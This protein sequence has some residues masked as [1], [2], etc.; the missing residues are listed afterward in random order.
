MDAFLIKN[1]QNQSLDEP[2]TL[3][4]TQP[5]TDLTEEAKKVFESFPQPVTLSA[6]TSRYVNNA[7]NHKR[8]SSVSQC[9][10]QVA[11]KRAKITV[12][13]AANKKPGQVTLTLAKKNA[14]LKGLVSSLKKGIKTKNFYN[15]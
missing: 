10:P 9:Q 4:T 12:N 15:H 2:Q 13:A 8:T 14:F 11:A 5:F 3:K 6:F 7:N 1:N